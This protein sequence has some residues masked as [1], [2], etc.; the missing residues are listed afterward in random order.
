MAADVVSSMLG[1]VFYAGLVSLTCQTNQP[2]IKYYPHV[3]L[4]NPA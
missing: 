3:R 2:R 1:V 4:T